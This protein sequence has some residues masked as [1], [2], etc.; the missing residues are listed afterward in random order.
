MSLRAILFTV[1]LCTVRSSDYLS[2][3]SERN[4][5]SLLCLSSRRPNMERTGQVSDSGSSTVKH[6]L[7]PEK[8]FMQVHYLK[9]RKGGTNVDYKTKKQ[10]YNVIAAAVKV[11]SPDC[12]RSIVLLFLTRLVLCPGLLPPQVLGQSSGR[13]TIH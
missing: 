10:S 7:N 11:V 13:T 2:C 8:T 9:V 4:F 1:P 6:A 12:L 3:L 5:V